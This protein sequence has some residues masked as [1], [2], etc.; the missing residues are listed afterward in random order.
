MYPQPQFTAD[1]S[2]AIAIIDDWPFATLLTPDGDAPQIT[3]LPVLRIGD[4]LLGHVARANPHAALLGERP[5]TL[6]FNGPHAYVSPHWYADGAPP[7]PTWNYIAV[8]ISGAVSPLS[9]AQVGDLLEAMATR[10]DSRPLPPMTPEQR[11]KKLVA[12]AGFSMRIERIDAKFKM[13]Q[14]RRAEDRAGVVQALSASESQMDVAVADWMRM[15]LD[16]RSQRRES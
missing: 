14:N 11:Q 6:L 3:H 1:E 8:H 4:E 15:H 16:C 13:S 12:I 10:F 9:D 5:S 7:V 2:A